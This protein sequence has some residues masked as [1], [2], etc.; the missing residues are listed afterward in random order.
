[1]N[2]AKEVPS[3]KKERNSRSQ[4]EKEKMER[5]TYD[6]LYRERG[7]YHWKKTLYNA[8]RL[9]IIKS[10]VPKKSLLSLD[11]GCGDGYTSKMLSKSSRTTIGLDISV[12]ALRAAK[13]RV[14]NVHFV[15]GDVR[16]LPF[17]DECFDT[18][19]C[20]EVLEHLREKDHASLLNGIHGVLKI[21][22]T[23]I[24]TTP[25]KDS[26]PKRMLRVLGKTAIEAYHLKEY[27]T[28]GLVEKIRQW[29][30]EI[31]GI[32]GGYL[33]TKTKLDRLIFRSIILWSILFK[34]WIL[35]SEKLPAISTYLFIK[36]YKI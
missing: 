23:M 35:I 20:A 17:R 6:S 11:L 10:F 8:A 26:L 18:V 14:V 36:A 7:A 24:L 27:N 28:S 31:I 3:D 19:L 25:N 16:N 22:G 2:C 30:F 34:L 4:K 5:K 13:H 33:V 1:M 21:R 32:K 15:L 9:H 12:V 29:K